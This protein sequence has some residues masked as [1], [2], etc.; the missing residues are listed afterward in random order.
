VRW[1][2]SNDLWLLNILGA[3]VDRAAIKKGPALD[4]ERM[5]LNV[6]YNMGA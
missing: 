2:C 6:T 5:M 1:G 3:G 4:R